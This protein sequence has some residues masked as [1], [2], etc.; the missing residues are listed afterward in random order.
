MRATLKDKS[1]SSG[2]QILKFGSSQIP[3]VEVLITVFM[4]KLKHE[5]I[6]T[7]TIVHFQYSVMF[8]NFYEFLHFL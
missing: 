6:L 3:P 7:F 2:G 4:V 8:I 5:G 1:S